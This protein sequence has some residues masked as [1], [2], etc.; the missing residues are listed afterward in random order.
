MKRFSTGLTVFRLPFLS[1]NLV[2]LRVIW[3]FIG[4]RLRIDG[5]VERAVAG[6]AR[7]EGIVIGLVRAIE[8]IRFCCEGTI[9]ELG[10]DIALNSCWHP[11]AVRRAPLKPKYVFRN[12]YF[13][14]FS[15][16]LTTQCNA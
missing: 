9:T 4:D 1:E 13:S 5:F 2:T 3:V 15:L 16:F 12:Y 11:I 6:R 8:S 10:D 7:D 14:D